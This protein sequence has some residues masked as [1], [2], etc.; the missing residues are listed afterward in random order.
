MRPL[1]ET[2]WLLDMKSGYGLGL[3]AAGTRRG[4]P[5]PSSPQAQRRMKATRQRD[6]A[7]EQA[8]TA[9][10]RQMGLS[11]EA[12]KAP[13]PGHRRRADIV[14]PTARLAVFVDGCFWHGCPE[15]GTWPRAN[16]KFWRQ[17]ILA[18]V[19]R[20]ADTNRQLHEAGWEVLRFW[21]HVDPDAAGLSIQQWLARNKSPDVEIPVGKHRVLSGSA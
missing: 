13:I 20:D 4:S 14:F 17:K 7:P 1:R 16:A 19:R 21:A 2:V 12:D 11:F 9:V 5:V 3:G 15:H 18:N 8:L 10:L 6:T